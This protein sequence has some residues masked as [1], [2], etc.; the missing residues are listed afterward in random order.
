M[1]IHWK[2]G[3]VMLAL[4]LTVPSLSATAAGQT[5]PSAVTEQKDD[6]VRSILMSLEAAISAR[7][8]ENTVALFAEDVQFIDEAGDE[9]RGR[10]ELGERF[11]QLFKS[12]ST[13]QVGIHPQSISFLA[14]NVALVVGEVSRKQGQEDLPASRFSI[15]MTE[16]N[17]KWQIN[18]ITETAMQSEQT[19]NRLQGLNWLIGEWT[20]ESAG[21]TATFDVEWAPSHKFITSTCTVNKSGKAPELDKQVIGWDPQRNTIISWHFDS[22]GGFGNGIWSNEPNENKWTVDVSGVGAD[23]STTTA[24]NVFTLKTP[25]DFVWQSIHRSLDG[26]AVADTEPLTVHRVKR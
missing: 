20:A 15:I 4:A 10:K 22:N 23:G 8:V 1:R 7:N 25:N 14:N 6:G 26:N 9:I 19:A 17:N 13:P 3:L 16:K 5:K 2:V 12:A 24:S 11:N 21:A 18:E